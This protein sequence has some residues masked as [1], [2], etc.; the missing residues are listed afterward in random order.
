MYTHQ[1]SVLK[2]IFIDMTEVQQ[3]NSLI[4]LNKGN[5]Y[6]E[7]YYDIN[8]SSCH[9]HHGNP[10]ICTQSKSHRYTKAYKK[11]KQLYEYTSQAD[12][13]LKFTP[14]L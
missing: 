3:Y 5:N 10:F 11:I 8:I 6:K 14:I 7:K 13:S 1:P 2:T 4:Q 9:K 12:K